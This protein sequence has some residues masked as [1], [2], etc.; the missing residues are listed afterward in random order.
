[1]SETIK[2]NPAPEIAP[3]STRVGARKNRIKIMKTLTRIKLIRQFFEKLRPEKNEISHSL[4][5]RLILFDS[6]IYFS[7]QKKKK[8]RKGKKNQEKKNVKE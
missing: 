6:L 8:V 7:N 1:M 2:A 5:R 3:K 4:L